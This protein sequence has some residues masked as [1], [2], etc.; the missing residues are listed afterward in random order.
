MTLSTQG[1]GLISTLEGF[2][3]KINA[4]SNSSTEQNIKKESSNV[5]VFWKGVISL[6]SRESVNSSM[7]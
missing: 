5:D 4:E 1:S 3:S 6:T 2:Q 7:V